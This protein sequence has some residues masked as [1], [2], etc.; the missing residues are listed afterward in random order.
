MSKCPDAQDA[1]ATILTVMEIVGNKVDL[2]FT[3]VASYNS[4]LWRLTE[5]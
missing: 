5:I 2:N 1:E 3:Y 4:L